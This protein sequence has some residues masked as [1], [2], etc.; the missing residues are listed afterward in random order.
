MK[1]LIIYSLFILI[2]GSYTL[3]SFSG[4][5]SGTEDD[6][7]Q[8]TNVNQLQEMQDELDAHYILMND[9]DASETREWNVRD[10]DN[11]PET[12]DSATGF[13]PIGQYIY[14][15]PLKSFTGSLDG[16]EYSINKLY[17]NYPIHDYTGLFNSIADGG[18]VYNTHLVG[19]KIS[20][21]NIVVYWLY[22]LCLIE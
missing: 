4:N 18:E 12:P 22:G 5:G 8:I 3:L 16:Q 11:D 10:H 13:L 2:T 7:Y 15:Q 14:E 20:E 6:P 17:I 9:I 1:K 21:M 19:A